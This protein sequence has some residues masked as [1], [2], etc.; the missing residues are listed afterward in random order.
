MPNMLNCILCHAPVHG[1][2]KYGD[3]QLIIPDSSGGHPVG[4]FEWAH[5]DCWEIAQRLFEN[6]QEHQ[7]KARAAS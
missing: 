7:L 4:C 1:D 6:R 3:V 2:A 5:G